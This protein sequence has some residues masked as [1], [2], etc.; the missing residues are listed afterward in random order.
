MFELG[1]TDSVLSLIRITADGSIFTGGNGEGGVLGLGD[2]EFD[3]LVPAMQ[4]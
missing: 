4:W 2:D 3:T 1:W